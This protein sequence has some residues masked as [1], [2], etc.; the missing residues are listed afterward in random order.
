MH[1][2]AH[3]FRSK[4]LIAL[5]ILGNFR[6]WQGENQPP[7]AGKAGFCVVP[8]GTTPIQSYLWGLHT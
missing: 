6:A 7:A 5:S 4:V 2:F 1:Q 3:D 8:E